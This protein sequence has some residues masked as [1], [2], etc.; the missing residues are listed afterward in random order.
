MDQVGFDRVEIIDGTTPPKG[1]SRAEYERL[2]LRERVRLLLAG[3]IRFYKQGVEV[4]PRQ[5][6][7]G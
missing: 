7:K 4:A 3:S 2:E 1:M 5:A 6:L